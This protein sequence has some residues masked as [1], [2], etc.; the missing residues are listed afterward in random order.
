MQQVAYPALRCQ[1]CWRALRFQRW[2]SGS[3]LYFAHVNLIQ[4]ISANIYTVFLASKGRRFFPSL[5]SGPRLSCWNLGLDGS[6][7]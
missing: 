4:Y 3:D 1:S 7:P 5:S 6:L 2:L